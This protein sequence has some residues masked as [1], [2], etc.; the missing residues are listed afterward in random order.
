MGASE[1]AQQ[2]TW[3]GNLDPMA[4]NLSR[5]KPDCY[6]GAHPNQLDKKVREDKKISKHIIPSSSINLPI[7]PNLFLE[8]KGPNGSSAVLKRHACHDGAVGAR[9]IHSLQAY[10]QDE[11]VY[12]NKITA[13]SSTYHMGTLKMY[14]HSVA[15]PSGPGTNPEY[16]MHQP[17]AWS[18]TGNRDSFLQGATA[19]KNAMDMTRKYRNA[20]IEH[21]NEVAAQTADNKEDKEDED[22]DNV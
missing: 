21:A 12:N 11:P 2:F 19:F 4:E 15:Q 5:A 3:F 8:A 10:G 16:C 14:A 6:Y 20:A 9:A 17:N 1:G 18:M 22:T 7:V 13:I